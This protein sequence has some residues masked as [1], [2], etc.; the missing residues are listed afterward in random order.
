VPNHDGSE[1]V[2]LTIIPHAQRVGIYLSTASWTT[3][4]GHHRPD[5]AFR[6]CGRTG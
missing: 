1:N 2:I 3:G 4:G 5:T 6:S